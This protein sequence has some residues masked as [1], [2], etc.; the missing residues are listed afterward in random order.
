MR[1]DK[2][3]Q[4]II[5]KSLETPDFLNR[6]CPHC[7]LL[8]P[9]SLMARRYHSLPFY[10][11]HWAPTP[12]RK[13]CVC[14]DTWTCSQPP[15]RTA[16]TASPSRWWSEMVRP[17]PCSSSGSAGTALPRPVAPSRLVVI[18]PEQVVFTKCT[19]W[20]REV[21]H[22]CT[23]LRNFR[24][25]CPHGNEGCVALAQLRFFLLLTLFLRKPLLS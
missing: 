3:A 5:I 17:R 20:V 1:T 12:R 14:T 22:V 7:P 8:P 4:G 9:S 10:L 24:K 21:S 19:G 11:A 2:S 6:G 23:C 16:G 25:P 15:W 18:F 13:R